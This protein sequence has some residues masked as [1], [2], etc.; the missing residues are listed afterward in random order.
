MPY[1]GWL[2]KS[3]D[4]E[5]DLVLNQAVAAEGDKDSK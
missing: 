5:N 2:Y 1:S 3:F 4:L